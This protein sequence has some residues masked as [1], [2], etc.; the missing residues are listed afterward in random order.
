METPLNFVGA[1]K[2]ARNVAVSGRY[3]EWYAPLPAPSLRELLSAAKLR[4]CRSMVAL[5]RWFTHRPLYTLKF[6][7]GYVHRRTLPQSRIRSTAPSE[8]EPGD[9]PFSR[10]LAKTGGG[11]R[12]SSPLRNSED[13]GFYHSNGYSLRR[14]VAGDFHRP[15]EAQEWEHFTVLWASAFDLCSGECKNFTLLT[16]AERSNP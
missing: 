9:V 3:I 1:M 7:S 5:G 11:G 12:F 15:Y 16:H 4:E 6:L 2:I 10:V 13:F 8:R 14:G